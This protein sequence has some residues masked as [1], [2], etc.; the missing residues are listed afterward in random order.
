MYNRTVWIEFDPAKNRLNRAK[1]QLDLADAE[2][3]FRDPRAITV[4]DKTCEEARWVTVGADGFGRALVVVYT[5]RGEGTIRIISARYANARER[6]DYEA[7][8]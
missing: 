6:E 5:W 7:R 1:H 8:P 2:P 4:E 3:V